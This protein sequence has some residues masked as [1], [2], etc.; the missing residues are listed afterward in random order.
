MIETFRALGREY[1][2]TTTPDGRVVVYT[3]GA[4]GRVTELD[5]GTWLASLT[6]DELRDVARSRRTR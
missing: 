1:V 6:E 3:R 4:D 5:A 2:T